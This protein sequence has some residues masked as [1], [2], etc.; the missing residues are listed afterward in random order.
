[1]VFIVKHRK[2]S[3]IRHQ[4]MITTGVGAKIFRHSVTIFVSR[5]KWIA[6][7]EFTHSDIDEELT[8][9]KIVGQLPKSDK[10]ASMVSEGVPHA[11]RPFIWARLCG[12]VA[13][14]RKAPFAY[15]DAVKQ[16]IG[17]EKASIVKQIDKDL[18]RTMP[19][20]VCFRNVNGVGVAS[21]RRV[22][23]AIAYLYPDLG[24]FSYH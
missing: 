2:L 14:K 13:K 10:L 6:Y 7:L 15:S 3:T 22:L 23:R 16:A 5:L 9:R 1:M 11:L 18:L 12:A 17:R 21:L 4:S 19:H 24:L 20:N 8:W